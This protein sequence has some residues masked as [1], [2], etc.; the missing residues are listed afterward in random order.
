M[1]KRFAV[2]TLWVENFARPL[3]LSGFH[4][5]GLDLP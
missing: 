1:I 4:Q 5:A 3:F 2:M